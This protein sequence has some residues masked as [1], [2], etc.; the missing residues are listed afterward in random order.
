MQV[1]SKQEIRKLEEYLG[2]KKNPGT[3]EKELWEKTG[4]YLPYFSKIPGV[5]CI[6]IANSLAMN[7]CHTDSDIDLFII[8]KKNRLWISRLYMT[9]LLSIIWQRKTSKNHAW[10]FCLSF[11]ITE[12]AIDF[13]QIAI[14]DDIYLSYWIQTLK[15]ILNRRHTH[16]KFIHANFWESQDVQQTSYEKLELLLPENKFIKYLWDS[17]ESI[18]KFTLFPKTKKSFQ[19]L[20]K[21]FWVIINNDM[22]KFHNN[23]RRKEISKEIL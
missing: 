2:V 11:F 4:K 19:K 20:W 6:C 16:E 18:I 15:P 22:L 8:T 21:P 14:K 12:D 1:F 23:D 7:A 9:L 13:S 5:L 3:F 17:L 10:K